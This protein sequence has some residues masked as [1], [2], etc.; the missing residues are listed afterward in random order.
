MRFGSLT[1]LAGVLLVAAGCS[2]KEEEPGFGSGGTVDPGTT[3]TT[4]SADSGVDTDTTGSSSD[5][6]N[7]TTTDGWPN[8][9]DEAGPSQR[10]PDCDFEEFPNVSA[11]GWVISCY[12]EIKDSQGNIDNGELFLTVS[13]GDFGDKP[14]E[15]PPIDIGTFEDSTA[16]SVCIDGDQLTQAELQFAINNAETTEVYNL[17][18]YVMDKG[19]NKSNTL[20]VT[21]E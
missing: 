13:G 1:L 11:T 6:T 18:W 3:E 14:D 7:S 16:C 9:E 17:S 8:P 5:D 12:V 10:N 19:G 2:P 15:E 4:D 21:V 20:E